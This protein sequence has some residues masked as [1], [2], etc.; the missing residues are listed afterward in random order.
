MLKI[1]GLAAGNYALSADG[2]PI[3]TASEKQLAEGVNLNSLLLDSKNTAPWNDLLKDIIPF[4]RAR[5]H[6]R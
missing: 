6:E 4:I 3:G 5:S 2:K 1:G